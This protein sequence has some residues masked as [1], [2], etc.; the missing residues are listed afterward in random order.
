MLFRKPRIADDQRPA[1]SESVR[2]VLESVDDIRPGD[3]LLTND[4]YQGGSHLPDITVITPVFV[5]DQMVFFVANR[6]HHADVGGIVPGSMP[7]FS[8]SLAEEGNG[9]G[10]PAS[11]SP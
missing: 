4:P 1:M 10:S 11:R 3:V 7:P 8:I 2:A 6:G 5:A 9:T